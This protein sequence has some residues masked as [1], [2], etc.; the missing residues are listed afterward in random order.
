MADLNKQ[1][2]ENPRYDLY[3]GEIL[4]YR[5]KEFYENSLYSTRQNL[6]SHFK[7]I[8]VEKVKEIT[9]EILTIRKNQKN[10]QY[11]LSTVELRSLVAPAVMFLDVLK[12]DYSSICE[13]IGLKNRY[14]YSDF[15]YDDD[16]QIRKIVVDSREQNSL[17]FPKHIS[18]TVKGLKVGDY[19]KTDNLKNQIVIER[20]N[21][22]DFVQ[23]LSSGYERFHKE[24]NRAEELNVKLLMVVEAKMTQALSFNYL[25]HLKY[26]KAT[27]E[28]IFSR[29]REIIQNYP[30][31]QIV[32]VDGRYEAAAMTMFALKFGRELL[33]WDVQYLYDNK[34]IKL[35]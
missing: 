25:P 15:T 16:K 12:V 8:D 22:S 19:A 21:L 5:S 35:T 11:S 2:R 10:L 33:D 9:K 31:F 13:S 24:L 20:K 3:T 30:D 28:F 1:Q 26:S 18:T 34:Q 17:S 6:I 23:T 27:P 14:K 29:A 7:R 32:F 4:P